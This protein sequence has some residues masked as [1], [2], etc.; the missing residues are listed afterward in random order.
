M[1][2]EPVDAIRDLAD[3]RP[4]QLLGVVLEVLAIG[5]HR[6]DAVAHEQLGHLALGAVA[7]GHLRLEIAQH[8]LGRAHVERD[9]VP[10]RLV[11]HAPLGEL[12]DRQPEAFLEDLLGAERIAAGDD[13]AD[14]RVVGDRRGP[15]TQPI[16]PKDRHHDVDVGQMLAG[17]GIGIIEDEHVARTDPPLPLGDQLAHG[18][19]EAAELHRRAHA[20]GQRLALRIADGGGEVEGIA[21]DPGV[22]RAHQRQRHVIRD[23]IEAVLDD[24]ELERIDRDAHDDLGALSRRR[25]LDHDVAEPIEPGGAIGRHDGRALVL[26]DDHRTPARLVRQAVAIEHRRRDAAQPRPEIGLPFAAI[27][28]GLA[29]LV[30]QLADAFRSAPADQAQIDHLDRELAGERMPVAREMGGLET[31]AELGD[32]RSIERPIG[33]GHGQ[34]EGLAGKAEIGLALERDRARVAADDP[35]DAV[36]K[37]LVRPFGLVQRQGLRRDAGTAPSR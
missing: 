10:K 18:V 32:R 5:Q 14:V 24:L 9:H 35:G 23:G 31:A 37:G 36:R 22:G 28:R 12:D 33:Q 21:D 19:V 2:G 25:Q 34:L 15:G 16:A 29:R 8:L 13:A 3:L 4:G 27:A 11:G 7:R 26:L 30:A 17:G 6:V 1:V 20:L